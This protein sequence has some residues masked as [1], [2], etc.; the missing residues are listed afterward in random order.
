MSIGALAF[1]CGGVSPDADGLVNGD[2]SGSDGGSKD[3]SSSSKRDSGSSTK[4]DAGCTGIGCNVVDCSGAAD[5]TISGIAYA[6]N[7]TT[8]LFNVIVFV[9]SATTKL[10]PLAEGVSCDQCGKVEGDPVTSTTTDGT[11][12]FT[13]HH[14]PPGTSI[15]VVFQLG[16][17]R[18]EIYVSTV[19]KCVDNPIK[20]ANLSRLPKNQSEGDM[21]HIAITTG[22]CDSTACLLPKLGIDSAEF[23]TAADVDTKKI[24]FYAASGAAAPAGA[25]TAQSL[26]SDETQLKKFDAVILGCNCSEDP[27][28]SPDAGAGPML[29]GMADY[30]AQGGR[31][32]SLDFQYP[33]IEYGTM[34]Q[35]TT[36]QSFIGGAP[37]LFSES[38]SIDDSTAKGAAAKL[39][40]TTAD[41]TKSYTGGAVSLGTTFENFGHVDPTL[42]QGWVTSSAH[43]V[44]MSYTAPLSKP[45]AQRCGKMMY[46]DGHLTNNG[47]VDSTFPAACGTGFSQE[48][49]LYTFFFMDLFSCV[50]DDTGAIVAP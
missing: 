32:L 30:L 18:R 42:A 5:T 45:A 4:K 35:P 27:A 23:G 38:F 37:V 12:H 43:D 21:P 34:P 14:V 16:K 8:P 46:F 49:M 24:I 22:T 31:T 11:G 19:T 41:P 47:T 7:G 15:P 40:L 28:Q 3:G 50:Q 26:W 9:P 17:W 33:W 36:M 20:D 48:Q 10:P 2:G 1:A 44:V 29:S 25:A 6:P 39:W 13:L